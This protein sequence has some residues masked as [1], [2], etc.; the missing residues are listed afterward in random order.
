MWRCGTLWLLLEKI[1]LQEQVWDDLCW[2]QSGNYLSI[3]SLQ[4]LFWS[5]LKY[6][7]IYVCSLQLKRN[8]HNMSSFFSAFGLSM[9]DC[10]DMLNSHKSSW[11]E[12]IPFSLSFDWQAN[13]YNIILTV[14]HTVGTIVHEW[15]SCLNC[16]LYCRSLWRICRQELESSLSPTT[17]MRYC[18][19]WSDSNTTHYLQK[20]KKKINSQWC[21]INSYYQFFMVKGGLDRRGICYA[22]RKQVATMGTNWLRWGAYLYFFRGWTHKGGGGRT[23]TGEKPP[24]TNTM[25]IQGQFYE[26]HNVAC[27][28]FPPSVQSPHNQNWWFW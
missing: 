9:S 25:S 27:P 15:S 20:K 17:D 8:G 11:K 22:I 24:W 14:L 28:D 19:C 13:T 21:M 1:S 18:I 12:G 10:V 23:C 5:S 26:F 4:F 7:F 16:S 3:F 2:S 6:I